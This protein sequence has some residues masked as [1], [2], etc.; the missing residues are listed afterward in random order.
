MPVYASIKMR[1]T[2]DLQPKAIMKDLEGQTFRVSPAG[3]ANQDMYSGEMAWAPEYTEEQR[4]AGAPPWI[5]QGD[6]VFVMG[7]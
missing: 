7:T 3:E 5:A 1:V 2:P 6:L 4:A